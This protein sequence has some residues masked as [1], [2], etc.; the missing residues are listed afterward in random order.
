VACVAIYVVTS[1]ITPAMD[2]KLVG[3]VCWDH[4]LAFLKGPVSGA[5]DP[6]VL[7]AVLVVVVGTLYFCLR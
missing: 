6:R 5:S 2:Q 1:L 4:P 7:S 3:Q